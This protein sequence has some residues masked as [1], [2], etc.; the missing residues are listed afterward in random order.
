MTMVKSIS[1]IAVMLLIGVLGAGIDS[2]AQTR[3]ATSAAAGKSSK[4]AKNVASNAPVDPEAK[5]DVTPAP[6]PLPM[7]PPDGFMTEY[8]ELVA[9]QKETKA[10]EDQ[11]IGATTRVARLIPPGYQFNEQTKMFVPVDRPTAPKAVAKPTPVPA[12]DP[13]SPAEKTPA[14]KTE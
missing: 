4:A 8:Y 3:K 14:A 13:S 1:V 9:L 5:E 2:V 10:K 6:A 7:Q 12:P 11:Y